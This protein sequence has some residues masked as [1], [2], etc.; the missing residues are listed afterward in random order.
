MSIT[1]PCSPAF[2]LAGNGVERAG[3]VFQCKG[4]TDLLCHL[5]W[6]YG[7]H[8]CIGCKPGTVGGKIRLVA[9][10]GG[11]LKRVKFFIGDNELQS[12]GLIKNWRKCGWNDTG[13]KE[14]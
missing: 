12:S 9:S 14:T 4:R 3:Q 5:N 13:Q 11:I 2:L 10:C 6:F 1:L 7:P 8:I